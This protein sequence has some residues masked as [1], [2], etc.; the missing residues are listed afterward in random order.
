MKLLLRSV[1]AAVAVVGTAVPLVGRTDGQ[2]AGGTRPLTLERLYSLPWLIGTAPKGLAWAPD[3][4]RLA[5]LWNDEGTSFYD[6]WITTRDGAPPTR[7][8]RPTNCR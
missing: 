6:V 7:S 3:S 5:F 4:G 8:F 2:S 1:A